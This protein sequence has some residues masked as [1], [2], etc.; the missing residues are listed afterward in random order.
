MMITLTLDPDV[1][2]KAR[3]GAARLRRPF[4]EVVN[5]ALRIGLDSLLAPQSSKPYRTTPRP[6]G[7]REEFSYDRIAELLAQAEGEDH[8]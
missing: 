3:E 7:V 1:A 4:K 6:M 8:P 2:A 5:A